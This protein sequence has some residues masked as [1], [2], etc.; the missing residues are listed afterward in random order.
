MA[1]HP[2]LSTLAEAVGL[3][4]IKALVSLTADPRQLYTE[5]HSTYQRFIQVVR[6]PEGLG[7]FWR[8]SPLLR[9]DLRILEAGCGTGALTLAVWDALAGR[10]FSPAAFH[11]FDLTPAM[12]EKLRERLD[13]REITAIDLRQANVLELDTLPAS[14]KDYDLLV[15]AS[16]LEYVP[17][18][19]FV[20]ALRGLRARLRDGG[21]FVLFITSRNPLM[22]LLIGRWWASNLYDRKELTQAFAA[23]G[24]ASTTFR[25]FP[26]SAS[27]LALWGNIVEARR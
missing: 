22:R 1:T 26:P 4:D 11:A 10:G 9:S 5:R 20:A 12:L 19:Q 18:D 8:S 6:Y 27:H 21:T 13:Q 3:R 23:A 24:F 7:A 25:R 14:W 15:S 2:E 17:R 16:M